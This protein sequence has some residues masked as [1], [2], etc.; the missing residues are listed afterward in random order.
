[1]ISGAGE[2]RVFITSVNVPGGL[3]MFP[4]EDGP[5]RI[6]RDLVAG[7]SPYDAKEAADQAWMLEW[8]DSGVQLFRLEK[9][10]TPPRH[11][12]VYAALLDED[13]GSVMLVNHVKA[14]AWLMPGGHVDDQEDPRRTITREVDEEL[15]I[16]PP[17]H[18]RFGNAPFFLTVTQTRGAH[19]H[20]DV[21]MWFVFT[22]DRQA[23]IIPDPAEFSEVR[24]F[25][26]ETAGWTADQFDP[27]MGRFVAK[28]STV[29][30]RVSTG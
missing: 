21:T 7:V 1:V 9:P 14:N 23:P 3:A 28:L 22:G 12:A 29:L 6:V 27:G 24:W 5:R 16:A 2:S 15:S 25:A 13:S 8:V 19:S 26:L 4:I 30:D 20:T 17:F 18:P 10:A 11:L